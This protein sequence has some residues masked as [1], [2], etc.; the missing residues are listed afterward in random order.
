M[1]ALVRTRPWGI[2]FFL[3][4]ISSVFAPSGASAATNLFGLL[5]TGEFYRSANGGVT[6]SAIGAIP[7]RDAV[8]LAAGSSSS[9]LY[10]ASRSGTVYRSTNGGTSWSAIGAVTAS[11]V[12]GFALTPFGNVLVLTS[13]GTGE[14]MAGPPNDRLLEERRMFGFELG[15]GALTGARVLC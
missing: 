8:G 3:C 11:D 2:V 12:A 4:A 7:V 15:L 9:E 6:W 5:D 1:S 13:T 10:L 14:L